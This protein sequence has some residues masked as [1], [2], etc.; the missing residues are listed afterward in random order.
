MSDMEKVIKIPII[1]D[2]ASALQGLKQLQEQIAAIKDAYG[3]TSTK[4]KDAFGLEDNFRSYSYQISNLTKQAEKLN[5]EFAKTGNMQTKNQLDNLIPRIQQTTKEYENFKNMLS[6]TDKVSKNFLVDF[7]ERTRNHLSWAASGALLGATIAIPAEVISQLTNLEQQYAAIQTTLPSMHHSQQEYNEVVKDSFTITERYGQSIEDVNKAIQLWGRGYKDVKEAMQLTEISTRLSVADNFSSE[8]ANRTIEGLIS[9]YNQQ[10]NAIQFATHATDA[11]TSVSHNAQTS[12]QDLSEALMRSAAAANA[13]GISFDE[14]VALNATVIRSTGQTGS[15]VGNAI[16]G[17]ANSIH[18]S[19][20]IEQLNELGISVYN[21]GENGE[22]SFRKITDVLMELSIKAPQVGAN[23]E[24]VLRTAAGGKYQVSRLASLIGNPAEYLRALS[25]SVNSA[26]FAD[27]QIAMQMDTISRKAATI[28]ADMQELIM[29]GGQSGLSSY[30]KGWLQDVHSFLS[31][32]QQVPKE[33]YEI[34]GSMTKWAIVAYS[35]Q[36][37][38]AFIGETMTLLRGAKA[39]NIALTAVETAGMTAQAAAVNTAAGAMGRLGAA[40]TFASGGLNLIIA[41]LVAGGTALA[42]YST[43]AGQ[44]AN[45]QEEATRKSEQDIEIKKQQLVQLQNQQDILPTLITAYRM[46]SEELQNVNLTEKQRE[47]LLATQGEAE[48]GLAK[49][50]GDAG[51]Q[52][53]QTANSVEEAINEETRIHK[54]KTDEQQTNIKNL[55]EIQYKQALATQEYA[56]SKITAIQNEATAFNEAANAIGEALGFI[57]Q[58]MFMYYSDKSKYLGNL[59]DGGIKDEWKYAGLNI[60]EGQDITQVTDKIKQEADA[61]QA[62]ADKIKQEAIATYLS[63]AKLSEFQFKT[64]GKFDA[65]GGGGTVSDSGDGKKGKTGS[66]GGTVGEHI[67]QRMA[68]QREVDNLFSQSKIAADNYSIALDAVNSKTDY[69]GLSSEQS[70]KKLEL[71]R[72]RTNELLAESMNYENMADEY[73]AKVDKMVG[74]NEELQSALNK[75]KLNWSDLSKTEKQE[76]TQSFKDLN[77]LLKLADQL[78]ERSAESRKDAQKTAIDAVKQSNSDSQQLYNDAISKLELDKSHEISGLGRFAK[79][80]VKNIVE[81]KYAV[82]ELVA[83]QQRLN[84]VGAKFGKDSIQYKQQEKAVDDLKAKVEELGDKWYSVR[85]GFADVISSMVTEGQSFKQVWSKLWAD[86]AREA[87]YRLM[88]V[89]TQTSLLG[90]LLGIFTGGA[91]TAAGGIVAGSGYNNVA[92]NNALLPTAFPHADGGIFNKEHLAILNEGNKKEAIIPLEQNTGR[93]INLWYQAGK[94]LGAFKGESYVPYLKNPELANQATTTVS[95]QNQHAKAQL[96]ATL[97]QNELI[98]S[99]NQMLF[100]MLQKNG[101]NSGSV[102]QPVVMS[103]GQSDE[104]LYSQIARMRNKG[105]KI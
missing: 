2:V 43:Y 84:D 41:G 105:Y 102:V 93:G 31:G 100:E 44:M 16:K 77:T 60:P 21:I 72:N 83:A 58:R 97:A 73:S 82:Q 67:V 14:L 74:S 52:R 99:Q 81:L 89:K 45:A 90:S 3:K 46:T 5:Q 54:T 55:L 34:A 23:L 87:I 96:D 18:S 15:V 4:T 25:L 62:Q 12:A 68:E 6:Y 26:G 37:A 59:A 92:V 69:F 103:T 104:G 91:S 65:S 13:V 51:L 32:L 20:A 79:D 70:S 30:L 49:I 1:V 86:L 61:A 38:L 47:S 75:E 50:V 36:K 53:I 63:K 9:S 11:L 27:Q 29:T 85:S 66:N 95:V 76:F 64:P 71:M 10:A 17:I 48:K 80:D 56:L 101:N 22:K 35:V 94:E 7:G 39:A 40:T 8:L 57:Q 28:K 42:L 33:A 19:K 98:K 88:S 24:E 78:R